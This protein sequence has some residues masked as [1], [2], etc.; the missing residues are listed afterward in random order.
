MT[1]GKDEHMTTARR[2]TGREH[3][4]LRE[5]K[6][7]LLDRFTELASERDM[8]QELTADGRGL[9]WQRYE[10]DGMLTAV[11]A[12]RA[13]LHVPPVDISVIELADQVAS[14]HCDY[15]S[16]WAFYCAELV[17]GVFPLA[18]EGT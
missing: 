1:I 8:R 4:A 11:N 3:D 15:A 7:R 13:A 2:L 12:E 17:F 18:P 9:T 5:T 14:G 6:R 10:L 16:K